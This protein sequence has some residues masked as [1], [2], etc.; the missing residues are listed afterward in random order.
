MGHDEKV[1][2]FDVDFDLLNMFTNTG[3][4]FA[5]SDSDSDNALVLGGPRVNPSVGGSLAAGDVAF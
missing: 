5:C 3:I 4:R 2:N 1:N